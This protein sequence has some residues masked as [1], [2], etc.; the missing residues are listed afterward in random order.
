MSSKFPKIRSFIGS[1]ILFVA[2]VLFWELA[3]LTTKQKSSL[4]PN[5]YVWS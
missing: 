1:N 4:E 5:A 3:S 2:E